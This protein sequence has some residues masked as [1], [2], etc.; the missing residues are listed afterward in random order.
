M[1]R[2]RSQRVL[3]AISMHCLLEIIDEFIA[4]ASKQVNEEYNCTD[5]THGVFKHMHFKIYYNHCTIVTVIF[6]SIGKEKSL[7]HELTSAMILDLPILFSSYR[8]S[9]MAN[10]V[11]IKS[12]PIVVLLRAEITKRRAARLTSQT[13]IWY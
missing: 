5:T 2:A 11:E 6:V 7:E 12:I 4:E 8:T 13:M 9:A 1:S 3:M 10:T